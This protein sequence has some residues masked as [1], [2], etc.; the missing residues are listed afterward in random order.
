MNIGEDV[1]KSK[2]GL[3]TTVAWGINGKVTYALEGSIFIAG[4][5]IQWLRDEL[6]LLYDASLSEQYAKL[7]DDTGGVYIVPAFTGLGAPYWDMNAKGAIFGLTRGTKREHI[8]RAMLE[9]IAYQCVDVFN[10][11]EED[12]NIKIQNLKVDGGA[13]ANGF[14]LQ[15]QSD[16]LNTEVTR[17]EI[18]E[19]TAMGCAFLAG[20]AV[21]FWKSTD[22]IKNIWKK[23]K[24]FQPLISDEDRKKKLKGWRKAV[25]RTFDWDKDEE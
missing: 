1:L 3:L 2:N 25:Q 8:I 11:I 4:A 19:T 6:R 15:F 24:I 17:P 16:M 13:S 7:V 14:L 23:D 18:L 12:T 5:G 20:L 9:S 21:G 10:C 22:E